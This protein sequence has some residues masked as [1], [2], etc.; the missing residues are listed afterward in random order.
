MN[1]NN[2]LT[3]YKKNLLLRGYSDKTQIAYIS[4]LSRY[5]KHYGGKL[6]NDSS[7]QIKDY[8]HYLLQVKKVSRSLMNQC[9]SALKFFYTTTL[10][11]NWENLKIPYVKHTKRLPEILS[12]KEIQSVL[13]CTGNIKHKAML[14]VVYSAGL[15]V[16]EAAALKVTD[17]DSKTNT[18]KVV[19]GKGKKDRFTLLSE[20]TL[21][22]LRQ[23]YLLFRPKIWLFENPAN[24]RP[25]NVS[26]FQKVFKN[27]TLKARIN[28]HVSIHSLRH[29]FATHCAPVM[30]NR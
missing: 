18:I 16:S 2:Y 22:A 29:S 4:L 21:I 1:E 27:A 25:L 26:T 30:V 19:E 13:D 17:I 14:M 9:Y 8:L 11:A 15:R 10:K 28:K 20:K 12:R 3:Q 24:H 6:E 7:T 5:F 23:Y